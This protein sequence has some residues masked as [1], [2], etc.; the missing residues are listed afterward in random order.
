MK[1]RA[2]TLLAGI[3][4]HHK[5]AVWI[6]ETRSVPKY[7]R[8]AAFFFF[9]DI[10]L[11]I[12]ATIIVIKTFAVQK[13]TC[14]NHWHHCSC[15]QHNGISQT[16]LTACVTPDSFI[17]SCSNLGHSARKKTM[18]P[19]TK[20]QHFVRTRQRKNNNVLLF[21]FRGTLENPYWIFFLF[22]Q[23]FLLKKDRKKKE[24]KEK[25]EE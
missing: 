7:E 12:A 8:L 5:M 9:K 21:F 3:R 2:A 16:N 22:F 1:S 4:M 10:Q 6:L 18:L 23:F 19:N 20:K 15:R 14:A 24:K 11:K 13:S 25:G 17:T